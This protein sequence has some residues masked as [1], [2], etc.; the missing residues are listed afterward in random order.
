MP[1]SVEQQDKIDRLVRFL[2]KYKNKSVNTEIVAKEIEKIWGNSYGA[3]KLSDLRIA[4]PE[5]FKGIKIVKLTEQSPWN[6]A[7]EQDPEFKKFFKERKPNLNWD[8]IPYETREVKRNVYDSYLLDI[9]KNKK[10]PKNYIPREDFRR[11]LGMNEKTFASIFG[12][13]SYKKLRNK[14]N[15]E[16]KPVQIGTISYFPPATKENILKFKTLVEENRQAGFESMAAKKSRGTIPAIKD[17]HREIKMDVSATPT[18]LAERIY[19]DASAKNLKY[20]G[21]DASKYVEFLKGKK[22]PGIVVPPAAQVTE[23][24]SNILVEGNGFFNFGDA[25]RRNAMMRER[26]VILNNTGPGAFKFKPVRDALVKSARETASRR[27]PRTALDEAMGLAGTFDRAPGYTELLQRIK[28]RIN[29]IKGNQIDPEFSRLFDKVLNNDDRPGSFRKQPY[30]DLKGHLRLFNK[31]SRDF[32]KEYKVDT[33]II[34]F[35]PGEKIDSSSFIKNIKNFDSLSEPAKK[36]IQELADKGIALRSKAKTM[37]Q[38]VLDTG[39]EKLIE[40]FDIRN[41]LIKQGQ[42]GGEICGLVGRKSKGGRMMFAKGTGCG[43]EVAQAFDKNPVKFSEEVTKLPYEEGPLNKVRNVATSFLSIAKKGGR[44]G[45]FA[46]AGAATA[47]LVKEFRNDDPSTYLSNEDQQKNMLIDMLTQPVS[48]PG[49]EEKTTAFG[50]AQLPAIGAVTAA[51]MVPGGAELYRQRTGSGVRKGPLGGARLDSEGTKILQKRVSPARALLGP[52]SGVLGKGL[53]A[54]GTPLGM[55]VLE[56]LY[57]GQ[58]IADGDSAGEIATNPLNYLGPAF[59]GSLSKEATRFV[60]PKM[61]NIMRLGI[62]PMA[63]KTV[64]RRFGLPGL[65]ISAG[66]SGYEMYQNKKAGRGIFDDG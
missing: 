17:F 21:N 15:K 56:P 26:D 44:F 7:W 22:V 33:A 49:L 34:D 38:M 14:L 25:E 6:I 42:K 51:G 18:E 58:Q 16:F 27:G 48:A 66:I 13:K 46:A 52:L 65:G 54:T 3:K 35:T 37:A 5:V 9:D 41:I 2:K 53:A 29:N 55:A 31:F 63:L 10:L 62:S 50:D 61:A 57:I 11:E 40:R 28:Q 24:L 1:R 32:Q 59:A 64:S 20:I 23:I 36:N 45:A 30:K 39:D 43:E 47:G 19:G 8:N 60:G 4:S 12:K